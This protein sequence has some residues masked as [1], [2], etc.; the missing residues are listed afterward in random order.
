MG[1]FRQFSYT[2][3]H[4]I[5]LDWLLGE[6][7][8]LSSE[9]LALDENVKKWMVDQDEAFKEL[10]EYVLN[11][12]DENNVKEEIIQYIDQLKE[13]GFFD[14]VI[15]QLS[16]RISDVTANLIWQKFNDINT[17]AQ[18]IDGIAYIPGGLMAMYHSKYG[19]VGRLTIMDIDSKSIISNLEGLMYHGNSVT[20]KDGK[21]YVCGAYMDS[22]V[23]TLIPDIVIVNVEDPYN[24]VIEDTIQPPLPSYSNGIYS[25]SY[26]PVVDKFYA[27]CSRGRTVGEFNRII[28]YDNAL[29]NIVDEIIASGIPAYSSQGIQTVYNNIAYFTYYDA[30]YYGYVAYDIVNQKIINMCKPP[31]YIN[32]YRFIGEV[33]SICYDY[34]KD[35]WFGSS[36]LTKTGVYAKTLSSIYELGMYKNIVSMQIENPDLDN[37]NKT[38]SIYVNQ[39]NEAITTSIDQM[40]CVQDAI[41]VAKNTDMYPVISLTGA[42]RSMGSLEII[43]FAG[44]ITGTSSQHVQCKSGIKVISS[45]IRFTYCDFEGSLTDGFTGQT[46]NIMVLASDVRVTGCTVTN[47]ISISESI[48]NTQALIPLYAVRTLL[49]GTIDPAGS[50]YIQSYRALNA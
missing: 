38:V 47:K 35:R 27:I 48:I 19:D 15:N 10:Q 16:L 1:I 42:D 40:V 34:E 36:R 21:L 44:V 41:N 49:L 43:N 32:N 29:E 33:E 24:P 25:L 5:N 20:Y 23:N 18:N 13:D 45:N 14:D 31:E 46:C 8:R 7:K 2:N 12:F 39:G 28:V 6:L 50:N 17:E 37:R 3:F 22:D 4:D 30:C 9:W 26:D 11:F